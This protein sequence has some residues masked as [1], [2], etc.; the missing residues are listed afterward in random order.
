MSGGA[1]MIVLLT[2]ENTY[3]IK[4]SLDQLLARAKEE[5]GPDAIIRV[6]G[7]TVSPD[8]LPQLLT[9]V[10]L[11]SSAQFVI[12]N[13]PSRSKAVWERLGE[14]LEQVDD[15]TTLVLVDSKPD[16]RTKTYKA[17]Q[18]MGAIQAHALL[19]DNELASWLQSHAREGG[20]D[21][22]MET[23]R[24]LIQY[25]GT[26]QWRLHHDLDKLLS[27]ERLI[28]PQL[29]RDIIEPE[30]RA[31]AFEVLDA[32][33]AGNRAVA[34]SQLEMLMSSE[35]PYR[36]FGLLASQVYA[37]AVCKAAGSTHSPDQIAKSTG[38][39]PFVVRKTQ[40]LARRYEAYE[41]KRLVE[42]VADCDVRMKTTGTD[43][44][45]LMKLTVGTIAARA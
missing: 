23:A 33:L 16:K 34:E 41:V 27:L 45:V 24:Y 32:A 43:P 15:S 10:S 21:L 1:A 5:Q 38:L 12:I 22:E 20:R 8:D 7:S 11:F 9:G 17:L 42:L 13:E 36:F 3:R 14:L 35:D 6:D 31:S 40:G 25:A 18:A 37:L 28:T 2:G 30:P 4:Q 44:W 19:Q 26:D 39:H 29:I